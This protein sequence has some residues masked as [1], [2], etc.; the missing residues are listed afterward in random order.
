[1]LIHIFNGPNLNLL[2]QR[3]PEIY[4][5]ASLAQIEKRCVQTAK[6]L[7]AKIDFRQTNHEGQMLDWIHEVANESSGLI[8]NAGAWAHSSIALHDALKNF[9]PPIIELHL[10]NP[11]ARE[12]FR[13]HSYVAPIATGSICG[14]G[15]QGYMLAI[16][17]MSII[18]RSR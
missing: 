12:H 6:S 11:Y 18:S 10:S 9:M 14:L 7:D 8:L 3:E 15:A 17:A 16:K 1:M 13:H 4:G 2:G 5:T